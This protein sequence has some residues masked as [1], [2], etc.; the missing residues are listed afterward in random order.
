[1]SDAANINRTVKA[2]GEEGRFR[3]VFVSSLRINTAP[4]FDLYLYAAARDAFVLYNER[5]R[6]FTDQH[7]RRLLTNNVTKLYIADQDL[8]RYRS[9]LHEHLPTVLAEAQLSVAQKASVLYT[10]A[11]AVLEQVLERTPTRASIE[12]GKAIVGHTVAFM[13]SDDFRLEHFLRTFSMEYYLYTHSINVVAYAVALALRTG[14]SDRATLREIGHGALLHDIGMSRVS[15]RIRQKAGPLSEWE[16]QQVK[17]HPRAG[18]DM[19]RSTGGLGEIA[20]DIVLHHHES[21]EGDGY[22]DQLKQPSVSPFVRIVSIA[23]VFDALTTARPHQHALNSFDALQHMRQNPR[24]N[25]DQHLL[26]QFIALMGPQ[27]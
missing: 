22:P 9:Y 3:P 20:L 8:G 1:M 27:G 2:A 7:L 10:S 13:T 18:H 17:E 12:E 23:N 26:R 4:D 25:L 15:E 11:Q 6:P 14:Y 24:G 5:Q 19:L 21:L 16:Y